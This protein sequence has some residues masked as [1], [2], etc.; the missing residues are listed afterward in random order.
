MGR[1]TNYC[2]RPQNRLINHLKKP[3]YDFDS[4]YPY[5]VMPYRIPKPQKSYRI[6]ED[7]WGPLRFVSRSWKDSYKCSKQFLKRKK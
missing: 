2:T 1:D 7:S 5:D 3:D 6:E 4:D